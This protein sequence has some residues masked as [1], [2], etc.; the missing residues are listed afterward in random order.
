MCGAVLHS[1]VF[2]HWGRCLWW[3]HFWKSLLLIS[4]VYFLPCPLRAPVNLNL[5][6]THLRYR[7]RCCGSPSQVSS[8]GHWWLHAQGKPY[9]LRFKTLLIVA[10]FFSCS[11][12]FFLFI[13]F[14]SSQLWNIHSH[15]SNHGIII[16]CSSVTKTY[17]TCSFFFFLG[18]LHSR[19][20]R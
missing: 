14:Y 20:P 9:L 2:E 15:Q 4:V 5:I 3:C 13:F 6:E 17:L 10:L 8:S 18:T 12:D 7:F 1:C 16:L 11:Y 19:C